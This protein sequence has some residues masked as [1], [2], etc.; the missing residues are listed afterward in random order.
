M[1]PSWWRR[2]SRFWK[3]GLTMPCLTT[4]KS[5]KNAG[6]L[7]KSGVWDWEHKTG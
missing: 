5:I 6:L 3:I 7:S 2:D 1:I 4:K